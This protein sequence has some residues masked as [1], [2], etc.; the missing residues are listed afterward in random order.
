M[1][2]LRIL[3]IYLIFAG[4]GTEQSEPKPEPSTRGCTMALVDMIN[5]ET[6]SCTRAS[7]G[8]NAEDLEKIGF[9]RAVAPECGLSPENYE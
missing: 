1:H 4:C 9:R 5:K 8:C 2:K 7:N 6:G 3:G